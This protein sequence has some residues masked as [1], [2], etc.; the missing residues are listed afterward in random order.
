MPLSL[1]L[2]FT[3]LSGILANEQGSVPNEPLQVVATIPDLGS[4]ARTIGGDKIKLKVIVKPGQDPHR[5]LARASMVLT[6]SRADVLLFMGL[7]YEH[8]FLPAILEK[9]RNN[10]IRSGGKGYVDIG[11]QIAPLEIPER[12]DRG[13]GADIHPRGNPHYNLDPHNGRIMAAV[14]KDA[15][16]ANDP[17]HASYYQERWEAWDKRAQ[18]KIAEWDKLMRPLRGQSFVTYHRSWSY[19]AKRYD[20]QVL[21]TIEPKP[22]LPPTPRHLAALANSMKKSQTKVVV[23]SPW[24]LERN[25]AALV[26]ATSAEVL[27]LY[28][29]SGA[30]PQTEDYLDYMDDLLKS[31]ARALQG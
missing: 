17:Q 28:G 24:Y 5:V 4:L 10:N 25:V 23:M 6:V 12:I 7:D 9:V 29:T 13:Q 22:G 1:L 19:L 20:L 18:E 26:R 2:W 14:I 15:L 30:T 16:I 11:T 31:L 27:K 21:G 8:A 3:C